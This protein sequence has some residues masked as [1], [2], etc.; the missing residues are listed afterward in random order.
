MND[1]TLL[2]PS[3]L[4]GPAPW[5]VRVGDV[6]VAVRPIEVGDAPALAQAYERLSVEA[7]VSRFGSPPQ[8]LNGA[9]LAHLVGVDHLD[10]VAFVAFDGD[11]LV[12]VGRVMRYPGD[13]GTLDIAVT[14]ADRLRGHGLGRVLADVLAQHRPRPASRIVTTVA[15]HNRA[16]LC[17][18]RSFGDPVRNPDDTVEVQLDD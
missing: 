3:P 15:R 2:A 9:S 16:A 11:E 7:R 12:G 14:V 17:L 4:T 10:H 18:L 5:Q 8:H 13:P 1:M 6:D